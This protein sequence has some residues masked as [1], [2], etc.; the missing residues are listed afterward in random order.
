MEQQQIFKHRLTGAIVLVALMVI[1][2][3]ILFDGSGYEGLPHMDAKKKPAIVFE[4]YFPELVDEAKDIA[5]IAT[6]DKDAGGKDIKEKPAQ[7]SK[8]RS[9]E[10]SVSRTPSAED[11]QEMLWVVQLGVFSEKKRADEIEKQ[12]RQKKFEK[13]YHKIVLVKGKSNYA[14]GLGPLGL[15]EAKHISKEVEAKLKITP[16][17]KR[18]K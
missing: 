10:R 14:V 9:S 13:I 5:P 7:Q 6:D 15:D 8:P 2:L 4:Q 11:L 17:I 3:P 12:L 1:F 18:D 16:Y